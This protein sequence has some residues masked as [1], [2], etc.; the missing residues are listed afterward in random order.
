MGGAGCGKLCAREGFSA[1]TALV[2]GCNVAGPK[3]L[4]E[5]SLLALSIGPAEGLS[6]RMIRHS[7][8]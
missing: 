3:R 8:D 5:V 7:F 2:S 6:C 4:S 1:L